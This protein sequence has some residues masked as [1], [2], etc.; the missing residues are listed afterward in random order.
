MSKKRAREVSDF[1]V[2]LVEIWEDLAHE[3]EE[4]RLKAAHTLLVK[5]VPSA[6]SDQIKTILTRLFRGLC[7]SR[8]AARLGFSIALAETLRSLQ[9][10]EKVCSYSEVL[11]ILEKQTTSEGGVSGQ[12]G[13][14]TP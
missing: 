9:N 10:S 2:A 4:I 6:T 1:H 14:A 8:K 7:S 11:D 13:R 5:F 3:D 12:V